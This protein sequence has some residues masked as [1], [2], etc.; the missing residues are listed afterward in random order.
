MK[1]KDCFKSYTKDLD[2]AVSPEETVER[3]KKVL[4]ADG[5][6]VL[7]ETRRIDTGRLGIPVFLSMCGEKARQVMPTRKQ[8]GKGASPIQAEASAL[9]E[10]VER[11]S[12]F[13][14]WDDDENFDELTWS[15][16]KEKWP[17]QVMDISEILKSVDEEM[18]ADQAEMLMDLVEWKFY[19][20]HDVAADKTVYAPLD[21]FKKL[22]EFNGSS[23]G[24]TLE[25]S[26][27]QGGCELVER[28]VC[29]I[30]DREEPELPTITHESC[31]SP[32]LQELIECF[33]KNNIQLVLKD[34]SLGMP[35]PTVAAV[36]WDPKTFPTLSEIVF[37]AG[38]A[39][40]PEKAAIR[41]IT[42]VAQLAGD[43]EAGQVYEPSGLAKYGT[44]EEIDWL[45]KGEEVA[46]STLPSVEDNNILT[47][48]RTLAQGLED[49]GY[50]LYSV[51]T[52]QEDI[53]Q[54]A[55]YNF[56]P[57]FKFRERTPHASLG[58]FIGRILA[59]DAIILEAERGLD[60]LD[61]VYPKSH[62]V[63]FFK[64]L[65]GVRSG[66]FRP[67][68]EHFAA[69]E[70]LQPS[71]EEKALVIFYRAHTLTLMNEWDNAMPHLDR[72]IEI[73]DQCKEFF[74][75]RG[76]GYFHKE[77]FE[78]AIKDFQAALD[79]DNGSASDLANLGICYK[80]L[81]QK[82]DAIH[83]LRAALAVDYN[84]S[85]DYARTA[86]DELEAGYEAEKVL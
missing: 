49:L 3:V 33:T 78:T 46:L 52:T 18:D 9:M 76:V 83:F 4:D 66:D 45:R 86:L 6:G 70:D 14:F 81:G 77:E 47:E 56:V 55:N 29:A 65:L 32:V 41:A 23:A 20:V 16:A 8:M 68:T 79:L 10:L 26:I 71:K 11:Y 53:K 2:K 48:L 36:A 44:I 43:F 17:G 58:M 42:E 13:S 75:L 21:W 61:G 84:Y 34:V 35:V 69:A 25:E 19:P 12:F 39:A 24:N 1:L 80:R 37:T 64:G 62:F 67:A 22:N 72:A 74:N 27:L 57:G 59:E 40:T 30:I 7:E 85:L 31:D 54:A 60:I 28:H 15:D 51:D 82:D 5:N 73:D 50:S 38:T 63:P